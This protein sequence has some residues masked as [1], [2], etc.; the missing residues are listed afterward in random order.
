MNGDAYQQGEK[1]SNS[2]LHKRTLLAIVSA[3]M[4]LAGAAFIAHLP[5]ILRAISKPRS[6]EETVSL[7]FVLVMYDGVPWLLQWAGIAIGAALL[8]RKYPQLT[9]DRLIVALGLPLAFGL[10]HWIA[11]FVRYRGPA[12]SLEWI[13][14]LLYKSVEQQFTG[15]SLPEFFFDNLPLLVAPLQLG[16]PFVNMQGWDFALAGLSTILVSAIGLLAA[17][18]LGVSRT[19]K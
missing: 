13:A 12:N 19:R 11:T 9:R 14:Q 2:R 1:L 16:G 7:G 17:M 10:T 3:V 8:G 18:A 6:L 5:V 15:G 4:L